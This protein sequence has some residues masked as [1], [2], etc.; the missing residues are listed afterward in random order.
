MIYNGIVVLIL[1]SDVCTTKK[2]LEPIAA[3]SGAFKHAQT[4]S[5]SPA[6]CAAG[7]AAVRHIKKHDLI[8]RCRLMGAVLHQKLAAL[9]DLPGVGDVRGRGLLAGIEFVADKKTKAPFPRS[10]RFA[11][12][13][14]EA[15]MDAGLIVWPNVGQADGENGDI[16]MVA[17]PFIVTESEIDE[18]V[19]RFKIALEAVHVK[20][21]PVPENNLHVRECG[22]GRV[23]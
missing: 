11:E 2:I 20:R 14:T 15:A 7:L 16:A 18:I 13:F 17:P 22:H 21:E 5:H 6:I 8:A 9:R 1:A 23:P 4:F 10:A 19:R 3:G 12:R